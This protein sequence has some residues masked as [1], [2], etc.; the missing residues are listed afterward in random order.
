MSYQWCL[1]NCCY[2]TYDWLTWW[3]NYDVLSRLTWYLLLHG[4]WLIDW[5]ENE[6]MTHLICNQESFHLSDEVMMIVCCLC[7][8]WFGVGS[9]SCQLAA[10][11]GATIDLI[12]K[13][14]NAPVLYPGMLHSERKCVHFCSEWSIVGYGTDAFWDL[15][16]RSIPVHSYSCQVAIFTNW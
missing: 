5:F 3:V 4:V 2:M 10:I 16:I 9:M 15:W 7:N 8:W 6:A 11:G 12:H 1:C 14:Q 13:P